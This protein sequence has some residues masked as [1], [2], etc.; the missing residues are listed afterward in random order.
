MK[1]QWQKILRDSKIELGTI[2]GNLLSAAGG[3]GVRT[4]LVTSSRPGEGKT[5][6]AAFLGHGLAQATQSRVILVDGNLRAPRLHQLFGAQNHPGLVDLLRGAWQHGALEGET[7][8]DEP[9]SPFADTK[10]ALMKAPVR[11]SESLRCTELPNLW[12]L[13]CGSNPQ[14]NGY[15]FDAGG[16]AVILR[17]LT[18]RADYVIVDADS[19]LTSSETWVLG[20]IFDGILLVVEC[21][22]TKWE[23][24]ELTREK[25]AKVGGR[26][27]GV[28][29]NKREYY[30]PNALYA[31]V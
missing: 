18:K 11:I 17:E 24:L 19:V 12:V 14:E 30:V 1:G 6:T 9:V 31:R 8:A 3:A 2:Q 22:K 29:L 4:I 20:R 27:L 7:R 21:A 10:T 25:I 16:I 5:T 26:V 13:P 23:V 28:V 15:A